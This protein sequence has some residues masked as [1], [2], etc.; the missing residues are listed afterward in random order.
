MF[1]DQEEWHGQVMFRK[2]K[3]GDLCHVMKK[4][5]QGPSVGVQCNAGMAHQYGGTESNAVLND[6]KSLR[7]DIST[8]YL[9]ILCIDLY[10]CIV[11]M[12]SQVAI[13]ICKL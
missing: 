2:G 10:V 8:S 6:V 7:L 12:L 5:C 3:A 9:S 4:A 11:Q 1:C 13:R